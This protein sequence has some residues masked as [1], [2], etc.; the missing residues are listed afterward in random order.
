MLSIVKGFFIFF[1]RFLFAFAHGV[2]ALVST[3]AISP[4][5]NYSIAQWLHVVKGFL[6]LF[7]DYFTPAINSLGSGSALVAVPHSP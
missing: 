7:S 5:D 3:S 1:S 2:R 6:E 4:L